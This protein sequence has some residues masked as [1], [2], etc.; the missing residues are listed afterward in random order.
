LFGKT[1]TM[2]AVSNW[3]KKP[4]TS[5][6]QIPSSGHIGLHPNGDFVVVSSDGTLLS[7]ADPYADLPPLKGKSR[8][9]PTPGSLPAKPLPAQSSAAQ[10]PNPTP[11]PFADPSRYQRL[12]SWLSEK[13]TVKHSLDPK[14]R[15][16]VQT[17]TDKIASLPSEAKAAVSQSMGAVSQLFTTGVVPSS[18]WNFLDMLCDV[19]LL[20]YIDDPVVWILVQPRMAH[21]YGWLTTAM[22]DGIVLLVKQFT[23]RVNMP[24]NQA[25]GDAEKKVDEE[26]DVSAFSGFYSALHYYTLGQLPTAIPRDLI[27]ALVA[28]NVAL[29]FTR[30]LEHFGPYVVQLIKWC[31]DKIW[32]LITGKPFF[33]VDQRRIVDD[34]AKNTHEI[35]RLLAVSPTA[36]T[37]QAFSAIHKS[38]QKLLAEAYALGVDKD[39]CLRYS[40]MVDKLSRHHVLISGEVQYTDPRSVPVSAMV[41]G[42]SGLGKT[43]LMQ[44]TCA[45]LARGASYTAPLAQIVKTYEK[46]V[47][48]Q[49]TMPPELKILLFDDVFLIDDKDTINEIHAFIGDLGSS[50]PVLVD[51]PSEPEKG[52]HWFRPD[53]NLFAENKPDDAN[54]NTPE[55]VARRFTGGIHTI[56]CNPEARD[57]DRRFFDPNYIYQ[58]TSADAII[59]AAN[60]AWVLV[61]HTGESR[62]FSQ[63]IA[64]LLA[65]RLKNHAI[66]NKGEAAINTLYASGKIEGD[67]IISQPPRTLR[68]VP[69]LA[70][71][72]TPS[73]SSP[74]PSFPSAGS[75]RQEIADKLNLV[76]KQGLEA[77][78]VDFRLWAFGKDSLSTSEADVVENLWLWMKKTRAKWV[79][80]DGVMTRD[81]VVV[82]RDTAIS[83]VVPTESYSKVDIDI[84]P[85]DWTPKVY[86]AMKSETF[87]V[88]GE[89]CRHDEYCY[90]H[91]RSVCASYLDDAVT[92][93]YVG[94]CKWFVDHSGLHG[95]Y[96][97]F[98]AKTLSPDEDS[99][100]LSILKGAL[101][102][103]T[104]SVAVLVIA[105]M[106]NQLYNVSCRARAQSYSGQGAQLARKVAPLEIPTPT[107][108][109]PDTRPVVKQGS[110]HLQGA[111]SVSN[112]QWIC[113]KLGN[114][115]Y[116]IHVSN[117]VSALY[118]YLTMIDQNIA[119]TNSHVFFDGITEIYIGGE[120]AAKLP[121]IKLAS[122]ADAKDSSSCQYAIDKKIDLAVVILPRSYGNAEDISKFL[123]SKD[124]PLSMLT[125]VTLCA[126]SDHL[127]DRV[128]PTV[129]GKIS[130]KP[131]SKAVEFPAGDADAVHHYDTPI[132]FTGIYCNTVRPT[133]DGWCGR[134]WYTSNTHVGRGHAIV[135]GP[136][137][138]LTRDNK[139][140]I[141]APFTKE[142]WDKVRSRIPSHALSG[143]RLQSAP[144]LLP[145]V[146]NLGPNI[147]VSGKLN[148]DERQYQNTKNTIRKVDP[149]LADCLVGVEIVHPSTN[150]VVLI[151]PID[152]TPAPLHRKLEALGKIVSSPHYPNQNTY[153]Q[154][155]ISMK[156]TLNQVLKCADPKIMEPRS[157]LYTIDEALNGIPAQGIP[158]LD[159]RKSPGFRPGFKPGAAGRL[160]YA[161][162]VEGHLNLKAP[163]I[164]VV[165]Y[166]TQQ[167]MSGE[168][169]TAFVVN[170]LKVELR[171]FMK[172]SR[173]TSCYDFLLLI[174]MRRF[175]MHIPAAV[176]SGALKN[177]MSVGLDFNQHD[178]KEVANSLLHHLYHDDVDAVNYDA[179][180]SPEFSQPGED[181]MAE[182]IQIKFPF[183]P[184]NA[185]HVVPILAR[186]VYDVFGEDVFFRYFGMHSGHL[187]T[188]ILNCF[189]SDATMRTAW[190]MSGAAS[191][192]DFDRESFHQSYGDDGRIFHSTAHMSNHV[193]V[194]TGAELGI[195]YTD[196]AK[197]GVIPIHTAPIDSKHLKRFAWQDASGYWHYALEL[198][199]VSHIHAFYHSKDRDIRA[200]VS[201]NF[202][203]ALRE[204]FHWGKNTYTLVS[205][206]LNSKLRTHGYRTFDA[207]YEDLYKVWFNNY[208]GS[209]IHPIKFGPSVKLQ[210]AS[211]NI[212]SIASTLGDTATSSRVNTAAQTIVDTKSGVL[213]KTEASPGAQLNKHIEPAGEIQIFPTPLALPRA[214]ESLNPYPP[215]GVEEI[216]TREYPIYSFSWLAAD[217]PA[218]RYM[219]ESFPERMFLIPKIAESLSRVGLV[220][221][222]LK[223]RVTTNATK[224]SAGGLIGVMV[225]DM[226][227]TDVPNQY[228][229]QHDMMWNQSHIWASAGTGISSAIT[230][231]W[232]SPKPFFNLESMTDEGQIGIFILDVGHKL[233]FASETPPLSMTVTVF[234]QFV[235]VVL[236]NHNVNSTASLAK[237]MKRAKQGPPVKLQSAVTEAVDKAVKGVTTGVNSASKTVDAIIQDGSALLPLLDL[238]SKPTSVALAT[239]TFISQIQDLGKTDGTQGG[240]VLASKS[241]AYVSI[242]NKFVGEANPQPAWGDLIGLPGRLAYFEVPTNVARGD[243]ITS[244]VVSPTAMYVSDIGA[245][246]EVCIPSHVAFWCMHHNLWMGDLKYL[247][248]CSSPST[249]GLVLRVTF[250]P[251]LVA[252]AAVADDDLGDLDSET[253]PVNGDF[254]FE[255]RAPYTNSN[256]MLRVNTLGQAAFTMNNCTG[257]IIV[258]CE[259]PYTVEA[260]AGTAKA[261]ITVFVAA[262]KNFVM[263][264]PVGLPNDW[265][266]TT[267]SFL[268]S[269]L[270]R[271]DKPNGQRNPKLKMK[272]GKLV[273][274]NDEP[275]HHQ[276]GVRETFG[277]KFA[278]LA[279]AKL[280]THSGICSTD[281][282]RGPCDL[283]KRFSWGG[284]NTAPLAGSV[285]QAAPCGDTLSMMTSWKGYSGG[286]A[287]KWILNTPANANH[288]AITRPAR[289]ALDPMSSASGIHFHNL[290]SVPAIEVQ[291]PYSN[292]NAYK[293]TVFDSLTRTDESVGYLVSFLPA[294]MS[295]TAFSKY[296]AMTDDLSLYH[297]LCP[298]N[299]MRQTPPLI[300]NSETRPRSNGKGQTL[301]EMMEN[302]T[303]GASARKQ[304][305]QIPLP[306]PRITLGQEEQVA[307]M[308]EE[309]TRRRTNRLPDSV[310]DPRQTE[311][312]TAPHSQTYLYNNDAYSRQFIADARA[313]MIE[314]LQLAARHGVVVRYANNYDFVAHY[315]CA[316]D[317]LY[318]MYM[319]D[320]IT[321]ASIP[322]RYKYWLS[323]IYGL[324]ADGCPDV[325]LTEFF[326][327]APSSSYATNVAVTHVYG[328][329]EEPDESP[330]NKENQAPKI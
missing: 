226:A 285:Q 265:I 241:T 204:W 184:L 315:R 70:P 300:T 147:V 27:A 314:R 225:P 75:I 263:A 270:S 130:A 97:R 247:F 182:M 292:Q 65:I 303:S 37:L 56:Y 61:D 152:V 145:A 42:S 39:T 306:T 231:T 72:F 146:Q 100:V 141:V 207:T 210:S 111:P 171:K 217:A 227:L 89:C 124:T 287:E 106:L 248:R 169:P 51:S 326:A 10:P 279:P 43:T 20:S 91:G 176:I 230:S 308:A 5:S 223:I 197:T 172:E 159:W 68:S 329:D 142:A 272:F 104:S 112:T 275:V 201:Q 264:Q 311:Y 196:S 127:F 259:K 86:E 8:D 148:P 254:E 208:G 290:N 54:S 193:L 19:I 82:S 194:R 63:W 1:L 110:E 185:A 305:A 32:C 139:Q 178:G 144:A 328:R 212:G 77:V 174:A 236:S 206:I 44:L 108:G 85:T 118:A 129:D 116:P 80:K 249:Q 9:S 143:V 93:N 158:P 57:A 273:T 277:Q 123:I 122:L 213:V 255:F 157:E 260:T 60:R 29:T 189:D 153:A 166:L 38:S 177:G 168:I 165:E 252:A 269:I 11:A 50:V 22:I 125:G 41:V 183:V 84:P 245:E 200:A 170:N 21:Q 78:A 294:D 67:Y 98:V 126:P 228:R 30:N 134:L 96:A 224:Y 220:S 202:E 205:K 34:M 180:K 49:S 53:F 324:D 251:S 243:L 175:S 218:T 181:A 325:E 76:K 267:D 261:M 90:K 167:I 71:E 16:L 4:T 250:V 280:I 186:V 131:R 87:Y 289:E 214:S 173:V 283:F 198:G 209:H 284:D 135:M 36:S 192:A 99:P 291:A 140:V 23:Q 94:A 229:L 113:D 133:V 312:V 132:V 232:T 137:A 199:V 155:K 320:A 58:H 330:D 46:A 238:L 188:T 66:R 115:A 215:I 6:P 299:L 278:P 48:F 310:F 26:K 302:P 62:N 15:T 296:S 316:I 244:F 304:S 274:R 203:S 293:Y 7:D 262:E 114:A 257:R 288:Y 297:Y 253:F 234:A 309:L 221:A 282:V 69:K 119:I 317:D 235:D 73:T 25:Y 59:A 74:A 121:L 281:M 211:I 256:M 3:L 276:A 47:N 321:Y 52:K 216:L 136:H 17:L 237:M 161:D 88:I 164:P 79:L 33:N 12:T 307:R 191:E 2:E 102:A 219:T 242:D 179:S 117:G 295:A 81:G 271:D 151:P 187:L 298:P 222:R 35:S 64:M 246:G 301:S 45:A 83:W 160:F 120:K 31:L 239:P 266:Y 138:A 103:F 128:V 24:V 323:E 18:M 55:S 258:Q 240:E 327:L 101:Y 195:T 156:E 150:K 40:S 162:L 95:Q 28:A 107:F 318:L 313:S 163:F 319:M 233:S 286:V 14:D 13:L 190:K 92:T 322:S 149:D 154:F 268:P 105:A 109:E